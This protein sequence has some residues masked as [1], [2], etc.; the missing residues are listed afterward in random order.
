MS[1]HLAAFALVAFVGYPPGDPDPLGPSARRHQ[2]TSRSPLLRLRC[3]LP[4]P[5][6]RRELAAADRRNERLIKSL[7]RA[8]EQRHAAVL[9]LGRLRQLIGETV[10][11]WNQ[12]R[13][14]LLT[15]DEVVIWTGHTGL[16]DTLN[17][18]EHEV[19]A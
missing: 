18:L 6:V 7:V 10:T 5:T 9:E 19:P 14:T 8:Q 16:A 1:R 11:A 3:L 4:G 17:Q 15:T 2:V 13:T 12:C